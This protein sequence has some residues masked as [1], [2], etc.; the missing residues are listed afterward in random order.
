[1][2]GSRTTVRAGLF[3]AAALWAASAAG[4][5]PADGGPRPEAAITGRA[6]DPEF[7]GEL[8]RQTLRRAAARERLWAWGWG[9]FFAGSLVGN[10]IATAAG[11]ARERA[12]FAFG[13]AGSATGVLVHLLTP[14]KVL[15]DL[16]AMDALSRSGGRAADPAVALAAAERALER[17]AEDQRFGRGWV[18]RVGNV[19][20]N[21][22]LGLG[23]GLGYGQRRAAVMQSALGIIIGELRIRTRPA[24]LV[25]A[26]ERY[27]AA[28][29]VP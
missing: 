14:P 22:A 13:A 10:G 12:A 5:G 4:A 11:E 29:L 15:G 2:R 18:Q 3:L 28:G 25:E 8:L 9:T 17:G 7:R 19:L 26:L 6:L 27:R 24:E 1:M 23:L 16:Q 20:F 21:A